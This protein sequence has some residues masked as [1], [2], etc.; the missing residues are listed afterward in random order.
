MCSRQLRS[1]VR[2]AEADW[3][4]QAPCCGWPCSRCATSRA[5]TCGAASRCTAARTS[6]A[7]HAAT[8]CS[9]R[10]V[11]SLTSAP[12]WVVAVS[13]PQPTTSA[14]RP[15]PSSLGASRWRRCG[16]ARR[17]MVWPPESML[18][19]LAWAMP[20]LNCAAPFVH[21]TRRT[22]T[23]RRHRYGRLRRV[24]APRHLL[25]LPWELRRRSRVGAWMLWL[26]GG[27]Q[28]SASLWAARK[29]Q[30]SRPQRAL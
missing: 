10:A 12:T 23:R 9:S 19:V 13:G 15:W 8:S 30:S 21:L 28:S 16:R 14:S 18:C 7:W 27:L 4:Q 20:L 1:P 6:N 11:S 29:L 17:G 5:A 26:T 25:S 22:S 24:Q 2:L 3:L